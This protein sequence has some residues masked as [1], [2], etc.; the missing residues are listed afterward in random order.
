MNNSI[1]QQVNT[2]NNNINLSCIHCNEP[3]TG[4]IIKYEDDSGPFCCVG[5]SSVYHILKSNNLS[6]YYQILNDNSDQSVSFKYRD[7]NYKQTIS[8]L[9]LD[10]LAFENEF[11]QFNH[12]SKTLKLYLEGVHCVAC[13]WLIEKLP[14]LHS[15]VQFSHL[16][17]SN[18][19][20]QITI[21]KNAN[22]SSVAKTLHQLGYPSHPIKTDQ[23]ADDLKKKETRKDILRIGVAGACMGNIMLFSLSNYS[24]AAESWKI[25]FNKLSFAFII[26]VIFYSAKPFF[27]SALSG[28]KKRN[29][30]IDQP[31]VLAIVIAFLYGFYNLYYGIPE[32]YFDSIAT[33]IFLL[34]SA[35]LLLKKMTQHQLSQA[36]F[37][38]FF[39]HDTVIKV[40]SDLKNESKVHAR[41]LAIDDLIKVPAGKIIPVDGIILKGTGLIDMSLLTGES[42]PQNHRPGDSVYSGTTNQNTPLYIQVT[43]IKKMTRLGKILA[44][45]EDSAKLDKAPI[46]HR[47]NQTAK[48]FLLILFLA[49]SLELLHGFI[50]NHLSTSLHRIMTLIIVTCPC[51]LGLAT[52][53]ALTSSLALALKKGIIIKSDWVLEKLSEIKEIVFDKTGTLTYGELQVSSINF[54]KTTTPDERNK[55]FNIIYSLESASSHPLAKAIIK[56]ITNNNIKINQLPITKQ[57]EKNGVGVFGFIDQANYSLRGLDQ[58][59][60]QNTDQVTLTTDVGLFREN[61][62]IMTLGLIDVIR[63]DAKDTINFFKLKNITTTI[64]SGD[65][66]DVVYSVAQELSIDAKNVYYRQSPEQK[67][68]FIAQ[69]KACMMVGDGA[70]DALALKRCELS[71]AVQ[72]SAEI[73]LHVSDIYSTINGTTPLTFLYDLS[74]ET[75]KVIIRNLIF[76]AF[77]NIVGASLALSGMIGPLW[78]AVLMPISSISVVL[79]TLWGTKKMRQLKGQSLL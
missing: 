15:F 66:K 68:H 47:M 48:Y 2:S 79:S 38:H 58:R 32:N 77:Y 23:H 9:Y 74:L 45:I 10:D 78:A 19:L 5:C 14:Q 46:I 8:Y 4:T 61:V 49:A 35:R 44:K 43:A 13:L 7:K 28:I 24:G 70:N 65:T 3:I 52:P 60:I 76:S 21:D 33:L 54:E 56:Y 1:F 64:L 67:E 12:T 71:M 31:I 53:L 40:S 34:L 11:V 51:A 17:F 26:P 59:K 62:L 29:I 27:T 50:T 75:K 16:D 72:G 41:Y 37:S 69:H 6:E 57:Y 42:M 20:T 25:L 73:G 18:S 63:T 22:F 36:D 55:Y 30:N 39:T